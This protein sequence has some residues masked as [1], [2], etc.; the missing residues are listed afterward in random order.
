MAERRNSQMGSK[1]N[2]G[3]F[4]CYDN[5]LPD[6]PM[7]ILLARDPRAPTLLELWAHQRMTDIEVG[8]R[9][10]SDMAMVR[11]ARDCAENMREWRAANNGKWRLPTQPNAGEAKHCNGG[12]VRELHRVCPG[13]NAN[14][15]EACKATFSSGQP[16][17]G[18]KP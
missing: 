14:Y 6:E 2:P 8:L 1:L 17:A 4:D 10:E 3:S 5:A 7:F 13:C 18:E 11:E 15:D 9:P 12:Y 16:N